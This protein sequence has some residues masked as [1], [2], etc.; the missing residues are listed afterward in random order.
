[1]LIN[2]KED[3]INFFHQGAKKEIFIGLENEKFLFDQSTNSRATYSKVKNVLNPQGSFFFSAEKSDEDWIL[4]KEGRFKHSRPYL[5]KL[6]CKYGFFSHFRSITLRKEKG[7][8]V[9]GILFGGFLDV[10]P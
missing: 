4:T 6:S 5:E 7:K 2:S 8:E 3:L 1:M 9:Q 10:A